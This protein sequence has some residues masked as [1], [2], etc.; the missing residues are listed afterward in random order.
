MTYISSIGLNYIVN[1]RVQLAQKG[2]DV[3]LVGPQPAIAKIFKMLGLYDV[4]RVTATEEQAWAARGCQEGPRRRAPDRT[5]QGQDW[6]R[7]GVGDPVKQFSLDSLELAP[8]IG[9]IRIKGAMA[10][11][12]IDILNLAVDKMFAHRMYRIILDLGETTHI[13]SSAVGTFINILDRAARE[14]GKLV[15]ARVGPSVL[16]ILQRLGFKD[17]FV[18]AP[19]VDAALK[20]LTGGDKRS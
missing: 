6:E 12:D 8:G 4:L 7:S 15:L 13:A 11:W 10:K 9:L 16:T 19:D 14:K 3:T 5:W 20:F 17:M 18:M 1:R 2:G